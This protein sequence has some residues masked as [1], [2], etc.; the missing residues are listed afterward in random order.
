MSDVAAAPAAPTTTAALRVRGVTRNFGSLRALDAV[1]LTVPERSVYGL[2]GPNGAGKT[3][4]FSVIAGFLRPDAGSVEI[5]DGRAPADDGLLGRVSILPQDALFDR[6]Q[7]IVDQLVLLLRLQ[8]VGR[9]EARAQVQD[10]LVRVGL[11]D[12]LERGVQ[13]L[14]HGMTKRLGIAQAF[15][16]DPELIFLDEPT[17]GLDPRNAKRIREVVRDL[18]AR[19]TVVVSSHNLLELQGLCDHIAVLDRGIV[20]AEG[21]MRE[22]TRGVRRL[23]ITL[24]RALTDGERD[25]LETIPGIGKADPQGGSSYHFPLAV[26]GGEEANAAIRVFLQQ[27]LVRD[28]TPTAFREG[29]S[30]EE[31]FLS[32]TEDSTA[33]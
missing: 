32:L 25:A 29:S 5:L 8:G 22:I 28:L 11:E 7:T 27:L 20:K 3:T 33:E 30:L 14:S 31:I 13:V 16:G 21:T 15:L 10:A 12:Y 19:A 17:A 9:R 1:E 2:V 6:N 26:A 4:L 18:A 23:E 24:D